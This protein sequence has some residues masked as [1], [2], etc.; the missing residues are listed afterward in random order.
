[1]DVWPPR[2][3][4][5]TTLCAVPTGGSTS[6]RRRT[7]GRR[8]RRRRNRR[9]S[10]ARRQA[11]PGVGTGQRR[12]QRGPWPRRRSRRAGEATTIGHGGRP[13]NASSPNW[14]TDLCT[15]TPPWRER[16]SPSHSSQRERRRMVIPGESRQDEGS[17]RSH[18]TWTFLRLERTPWARSFLRLERT[19]MLPGQ[20]L[21]T[22][23]APG[24]YRETPPTR[25]SPGMSKR[26]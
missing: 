20:L 8:R 2:R 19:P 16:R 9:R 10:R 12:S 14:I 21:P 25:E 15:D 4:S 23:R 17:Q 13:P 5:L 1:M 22:E 26:G 3:P 24:T 7:Q 11:Q 6:S 18:G